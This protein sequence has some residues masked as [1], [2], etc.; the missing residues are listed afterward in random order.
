MA[1]SDS[2]EQTKPVDIAPNDRFSVNGRPLPFAEFV[3]AC[4]RSFA[5][6]EPIEPEPQRQPQP[7]EVIW[8]S[9]RPQQPAQS[10]DE[11]SLGP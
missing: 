5:A 1:S 4:M 6:R 7:W 8:T 3:E 2:D 10:A 9:R 11:E